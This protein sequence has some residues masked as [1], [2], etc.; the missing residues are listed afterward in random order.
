MTTLTVNQKPTG[1]YVVENNSPAKN[2]TFGSWNARKIA[3]V[4]AGAFT[5]LLLLGSGTAAVITGAVTGNPGL[6][7]LG[8]IAIGLGLI[9]GTAAFMVARERTSSNLDS[10]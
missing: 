4:A 10:M 2:A 3:T 8:V 7:A 6:I 5:A 1:S 9:F